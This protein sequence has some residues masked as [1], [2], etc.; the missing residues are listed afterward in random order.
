MGGGLD[1]ISR[2]TVQVHKYDA[3]GQ[4]VTFVTANTYSVGTQWLAEATILADGDI[5]VTWASESTPGDNSLWGISA[6]RFDADLNPLGDEFLVTEYTLNSQLM[7]VV[8]ALPDGD[9]V[10]AWQG[11]GPANGAEEHGI[12]MRRFSAYSQYDRISGEPT[13]DDTITISDVDNSTLISATVQISGGLVAAEDQLSFTA[14]AGS[15]IQGNYDATNGILSLFGVASISN[16]EATLRSVTYANADNISPTVGIKTFSFRVNDGSQENNLSNLVE[17]RLTVS[18]ENI[19]PIIASDAI[20][21][22]EDSPHTGQLSASDFEGDPLTY[23]LGAGPANGSV[24]VNVDGTYTY[25]PNAHFSGSDSFTISV[26]D[27][28]GGTDTGTV[29]IDVAP[30]ADA[31]TVTASLGA[32]TLTPGSPVGT[33]FQVNTETEGNQAQSSVAGLADGGYVVTWQSTLTNNHSDLEVFG[34]RYDASGRAIGTEFQINSFTTD[35]QRVPTVTGLADGGFVVTW[36]SEFQDGSGFGVYGQRFDA[37]GSAIGQEFQV[38]SDVFANQQ[39]PD[40]EALADGGFVV[41]WNSG[42]GPA[43]NIFG[44]RFDAQGIAV[45]S[46]F[47]IN[48]AN[49]DHTLASIA[50]LEDGGFFVTWTSQSSLG[51]R[52]EV[53][54]QRFD[55]AGIPVGSEFRINSFITADQ[56]ASTVTGLPDGGFLVTWTSFDQDGDGSGIFGQRFDADSVA[57]GSEFQVNTVTIDRQTNSTV[58]AI[59]DGGFV[60]T[61][62]SSGQDGD[63]FGIFGQRYAADGSPLSGEFQINTTTVDDQIVL[64]NSVTSL[65]DGGFVVTWSSNNPCLS[66]CNPHPLY[67]GCAVIRQARVSEWK[68]MF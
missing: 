6:R 67:V 62:M 64:M 37:Q 47:Q 13:I 52:D 42:S 53:V 11:I 38:N 18:D 12:W 48:T 2:N 30:V 59:A 32:W 17:R 36:E 14:P 46:E 8:T 29:T 10:I 56:V 22:V 1:V 49:G 16:Y 54:G 34:Q 44:Q 61:W 5:L 21:V 19:A 55:V 7:P 27:G 24:A 23:A 15:G 26:S 57:V 9:F 50:A 65:Q 66:G 28:N 40:I 39:R 35:A 60:V 33:E 3:N 45:G 31:P 20:T 68:L 25:T 51:N 4:H 41:A 58:T 63:G 43:D